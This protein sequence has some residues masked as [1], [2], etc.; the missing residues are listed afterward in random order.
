MVVAFPKEKAR[1]HPHSPLYL[2]PPLWAGLQEQGL[3]NSSL[4]AKS[5]LP[6]V[7]MNIVLLEHSP[8]HCT[9]YGCLPTATAE[10]TGCNRGCVTRKV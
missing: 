6:P 3:A 4:R 10:L 9:V 1:S 8:L 5:S 2:V 7:S